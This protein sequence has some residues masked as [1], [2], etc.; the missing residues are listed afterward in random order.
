M[1]RL[2]ALLA[3]LLLLSRSTLPEPVPA[4]APAVPCSQIVNKL[5]PCYSYISGKEDEPTQP[6]CNGVKEISDA[7]KS[8][9]DKQAACECIKGALSKIKY[10]PNLIPQLPKK[11]GVPIN[12]PPIGKDT[13]CTQ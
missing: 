3:L 10:D 8:K 6:C 4:A 12:L 7:I 9:A 5:T 11:C 1:N 13:D 2:L